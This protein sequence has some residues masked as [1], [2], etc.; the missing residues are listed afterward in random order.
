M[1]GEIKFKV[2]AMNAIEIAYSYKKNNKYVFI[3][4]ILD[5]LP[6]RSHIPTSQN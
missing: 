4:Q 1:S 6:C 2:K 3:M 5:I